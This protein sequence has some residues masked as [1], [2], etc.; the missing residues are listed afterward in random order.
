MLSLPRVR[1][2]SLVGELRSHKPQGAAKKT[3]NRKT[4]STHVQV[5]CSR[6]ET[7]SPGTRAPSFPPC[8][9][10][11]LGAPCE[12]G[13]TWEGGTTEGHSPCSPGPREMLR[14]L[15][16]QNSSGPRLVKP[17]LPTPAA[18]LSGH[19]LDGGSK[20]APLLRNHQVLP[21]L[22]RKGQLSP[23]GHQGCQGPRGALHHRSWP[24]Q[25]MGTS[26]GTSPSPSFL[27]PHHRRPS[28]GVTLEN[29]RSRK[30]SSATTKSNQTKPNQKGQGQGRG[31]YARPREQNHTTPLSQPGQRGSATGRTGDTR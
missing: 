19:L 23:E 21:A 5:T 29:S 8:S 16:R 20:E 27:T 13:C 24:R 25:D 1:V 22:G 2:G 14:E 18:P 30:P 11:I 31:R 15:L 10:W 17:P 6:P 7:S 26:P 28:E 12:V 4:C 9:P 3:K